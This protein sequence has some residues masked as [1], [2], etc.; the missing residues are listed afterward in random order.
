[1]SRSRHYLWVRSFIAAS[2]VAS[3]VMSL[4][5]QPHLDRPAWSRNADGSITWSGEAFF[6]IV[7]PNRVAVLLDTNHDGSIDRGFAIRIESPLEHGPSLHFESAHVE[8]LPGYIRVVAGRQIIEFVTP[9]ATIQRS[10]PPGFEIHRFVGYEI[11]SSGGE[12]G[13]AIARDRFHR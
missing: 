10:I 3:V 8:E 7:G 5:A 13:I 12:T 6:K 2:F 9:E 1:L 11:L 4:S